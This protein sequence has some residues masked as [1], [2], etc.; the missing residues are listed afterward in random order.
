[1]ELGGPNSRPEQP[2]QVSL[3]YSPGILGVTGS[4]K[5][6][7]FLILNFIIF[8]FLFPKFPNYFFPTLFIASWKRKGKCVLTN[9]HFKPQ[10][11]AKPNSLKIIKPPKNLKN[12]TFKL[13]TKKKTKRT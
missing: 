3:S 10:N 12:N 11:S 4:I 1:M 9:K 6:F 7:L 13:Q 8:F 5:R 2:G